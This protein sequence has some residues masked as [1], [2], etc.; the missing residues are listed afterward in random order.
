MA[1]LSADAKVAYE[2]VRND[3][4]PTNWLL[5]EYADDKSDNIILSASG[6]GGLEEAKTKLDD[7]KPAFGF[8]RVVVGNDAL[9]QR[10][11]FLFFTWCGVGVKVMRKAKLSIHIANVKQVLQTFS[12]EVSATTLDDLTESEMVSLIK[13]SMGANYDGQGTR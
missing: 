6:N 3:S 8:V 5:L 7:N 13:K 10:V 2:D 9:S 12:V 4:T 1:T 11:K